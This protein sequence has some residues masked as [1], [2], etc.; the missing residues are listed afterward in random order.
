VCDFV[1]AAMGALGNR[2]GLQLPVGP[3]LVAAGRRSFPFGYCHD[4]SLKS[5]EPG[6]P[7]SD[8]LYNFKETKD[9][10]PPYRLL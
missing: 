3:A 2:S 5:S 4:N 10:P 6:D 7:V 8:T 9:L 1:L